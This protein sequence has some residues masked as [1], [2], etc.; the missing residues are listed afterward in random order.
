MRNTAIKDSWWI[1][2]SVI[3]NRL[4][5]KTN[6]MSGVYTLVD[7]KWYSS[8]WYTDLM[9]ITELQNIKEMTRLKIKMYLQA[10]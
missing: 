4:Y 8:S 5:G 6:S 3:A 7:F 1:D 10:K 2:N 9:N